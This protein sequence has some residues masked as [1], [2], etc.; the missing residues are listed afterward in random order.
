MGAEGGVPRRA[1]LGGHGDGGDEASSGDGEEGSALDKVKQRGQM[2]LGSRMDWD[3]LSG[4]EGNDATM[5]DGTDVET[6]TVRA[7]DGGGAC[8]RCEVPGRSGLEKNRG[9][10][11]QFWSGHGTWPAAR[12]GAVP[13]VRQR[14]NAMRKRE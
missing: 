8:R 7:E 1:E 5:R 12:D 11:K 4:G 9:C 6:A 14:A 3:G 10:G 13:D 2:E